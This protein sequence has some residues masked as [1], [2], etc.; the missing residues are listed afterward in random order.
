MIKV[1]YNNRFNG[2]LR[3]VCAIAIGLLMVIRPSDAMSVVV[4]VIASFLL[5]SGLVSLI[6]GLRSR[7]NGALPLMSFNALVDVALAAF[8]FIFPGFVARF[9]IY[10]IGL[11]LLIFGGLQLAG[12][13]SVRK[14]LSL[15]PGTFVLPVLITFAGAFILFNPFA[16]SVMSIIAGVA[17]L[18]Y[19]VSEIYSSWKMGTLK[20]PDDTTI[21]DQ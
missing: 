4:K 11:A 12:L 18:I 14:S 9:V 8:L 13:I 16:E 15:N 3:A 2:P 10:L 1:G 20:N 17:F 6:Q 5:A 21:D 7:S 19:G